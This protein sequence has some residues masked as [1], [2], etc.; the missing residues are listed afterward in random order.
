M[1]NNFSKLEYEI[2]AFLIF[3][4]ISVVGIISAATVGIITTSDTTKVKIACYESAKTNPN[5]KCEDIR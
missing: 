1:F 2:K 4:V 5:L 3:M